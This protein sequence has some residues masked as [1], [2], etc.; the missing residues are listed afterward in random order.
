MGFAGRILLKE[1][2]CP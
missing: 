2:C 1:W